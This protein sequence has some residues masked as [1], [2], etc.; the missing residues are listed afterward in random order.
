M[1]AVRTERQRCR[2][3]DADGNKSSECHAEGR[4]DTVRR[5]VLER[6]LIL[7]RA[8]RIEIE[9]VRLVDRSND[10]DRDEP[11]LGCIRRG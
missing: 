8:R 10:A 7:D 1:D 11:V 9:H 5:N 2:D 6:P 3:E 4:D